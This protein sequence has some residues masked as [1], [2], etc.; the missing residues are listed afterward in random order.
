MKN[1]SR[2]I[3]TAALICWFALSG[4][5]IANKTS[6]KIVAPGKAAKGTEITIEIHVTH[7]GN[8]FIHHTDWVYVA[9]DGKELQRWTFSSFDKPEDEQFVRSVTYTVSKPIEITAEGDCN[10]HGS[11]GITT[12]RVDVE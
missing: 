11:A 8:N 12:M 10:L 3:L 2:F 1:R 7:E 6:V 4:V 9:I 5:A